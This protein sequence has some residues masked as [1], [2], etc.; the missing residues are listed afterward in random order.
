MILDAFE[1]SYLP[2]KGI[3]RYPRTSEIVRPGGNY[4]RLIYL[5][6]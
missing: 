1:R 6:L 4:L 3:A 2:G 5:I